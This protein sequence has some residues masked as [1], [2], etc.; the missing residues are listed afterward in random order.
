[1]ADTKK[2]VKAFLVLGAVVSLVM[3]SFSSFFQTAYIQPNNNAKAEN[4]TFQYPQNAFISPGG[5]NGGLS[6]EERLLA[7]KELPAVKPSSNLT[8]NLAQNLAREVIIANPDGVKIGNDGQAYIN[9]PD[10]DAVKTQLAADPGLKKI[11]IPDWESAV[12]YQN[13]KI[14]ENY[15]D[16]DLATYIQ[17]INKILE[18]RFVKTDVDQL[19]AAEDSSANNAALA[20]EPIESA[21]KDALT[22]STPKPLLGFQKSIAR[23]LTYESQVLKL[24]TNSETDPLKASLIF[25]AQEKNYN[26]A[27]LEL[28][29][30][31]QKLNSEKIFSD[32]DK[33][34]I[35]SL[36]NNIL[37]V[38][39]ARAFIFVPT[40]DAI[41]THIS[42]ARKI[43]E[44]AQQVLLQLLKNT[45]TQLFQN[46]VLKFIQNNG[47][48]RFIRNWASTLLSA[49]ALG[50]GSAAQK[51][52]PALCSSFGPMV[53]GN[54]LPSYGLSSAGLSYG[55]CPLEKLTNGN[56][57]SFYSDFSKGG[58]LAYGASILPSSNYYG[59][60][61]SFA[62]Q[63]ERAAVQ[64]QNVE[65]AKSIANQGFK[66]GGQQA[67]Q[68]GNPV[69]YTASYTEG[70]SQ[71]QTDAINTITAK[72]NNK[73]QDGGY[74]Q[75]QPTTC[76]NGTCS[77]TLCPKSEVRA[78]QL[79]EAINNPG[80][81][82]KGL[83]DTAIKSHNDLSVNA[84][85]LAGLFATIA[86]SFVNKIL[87]G[88]Q[89]LIGNTGSET[90]SATPPPPPSGSAPTQ[91]PT[92][93]SPQSQTVNSGETATFDASGGDGTYS[94]S[95]PGGNP[96]SATVD[97]NFST[98][99]VNQTASPVTNTV[100]V[101][102]NNQSAS[103]SVTVQ[104]VISGSTYTS[105]SGPCAGLTGYDLYQCE[106]SLSP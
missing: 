46:Y 31:I 17:N 106:Q 92:T 16:E 74:M 5:L 89:S 54:I 103:C 58:W 34:K 3:L 94:W 52:A 26:L 75:V 59:S 21:L 98:V 19:L 24:V 70:N 105:T 28:N 93:C 78:G 38:K 22:L 62:N 12:P 88:N 32:S 85:N 13:I 72:I 69:T 48:A 27:L 1:M 81:A 86:G 37:G 68:C 67:G 10:T 33:N 82:V 8:D 101:T 44:F 80:Q 4:G 66:S 20:A 96:T 63:L 50:A 18:N 14:S 84:N 7:E 57:S 71:S 60:Q 100:T 65:Q 99:F 41:Q 73:V 55:N 97:A 2:L 83:L 23:T 102:S 104:P 49:Y 25:Q 51:L 56:P 15:S 61:F 42:L 79:A 95:A 76:N 29:N 64:A 91:L 36:L 11:K 6:P 30:E 77:A 39:V 47:D 53:T 9:P 40:H 87:T 43:W 90:S 45:I 35:L